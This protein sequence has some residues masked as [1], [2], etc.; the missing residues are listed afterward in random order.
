[1]SGC[2]ERQG[3][4]ANVWEMSGKDRGVIENHCF[5]SHV[6]DTLIFSSLSKLS[7][8]EEDP[9]YN[10]SMWKSVIL[11]DVW[12]SGKLGVYA[13]GLENVWTR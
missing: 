4:Q 6:A 13:K 3:C 8:V 10:G 7:T 5:L 11:L 9:P 2:L 12:K 1:M